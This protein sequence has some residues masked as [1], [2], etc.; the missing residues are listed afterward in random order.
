MKNIYSYYFI[1]ATLCILLQ[2]GTGLSAEAQCPYGGPSGGVAYDTTIATPTG[3]NTLQLK[4]PKSHPF[5]GMLTCMKLCI[6]I[7]GVVDSV[8]VENNSGGVATADVFYIRTDQI[9]GPGLITPLTNSINHHYGPY[10]LDPSDGNLGSGPDFVAISKDTLLNAVSQCRTITDPAVLMLF[11]GTD[12]VTYNYDITAF[13]NISCSG[14]NYNSMV[15]TSALVN[16]H[17]EYCLC[18]DY[19]LPLSISNFFVTKIADNKAKLTWSAD[20][21]NK[22]FY[23]Y[24]TEMSRDGIHFSTI[25]QVAKNTAVNDPYNFIYAT[26]QNETGLFFFRIKQVYSTGYTRFSDIRQ[27]TLVNSTL[28]K[29]TVY[30]NPSDGIVGIKFDNIQ[31]GKMMIQVYNTHGQT[32][33]E[34]EIVAT[35]SS[36]QQIARLQSGVYW[37]KLTDATSKLSCVN[38]LLIK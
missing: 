1:T 34:K 20:D 32:V 12:S 10:S 24:E 16:F 8:S 33:V 23:H 19:I 4:F 2:L 25:G 5:S 29:F 37:V 36:Y 9:T 35:E 7:T 13:T 15:A 26:G 18:P 28:P 31:G 30:P 11:Y 27:I 3:I 22:S 14:G 6:S 17:F 21:D 38:Q